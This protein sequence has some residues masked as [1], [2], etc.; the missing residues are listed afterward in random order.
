MNRSH[1][2]MGAPPTLRPRTRRSWLVL[3][4]A[5]PG[6]LGLAAIGTPAGAVQE[7]PAESYVVVMAAEPV[8]AYDGGE[9]GLAPTDPAVGEDID[10]DDPAVERYVE[11]LEAEQSEAAR[12]AGVDAADV[13]ERY[14]YAISGFEAELT[15]D[16]ASALERSTDVL[17]VVPN[18]LRQ[19]HTDVSPDFL[20]LDGPRGPYTW[21]YTGEDVVVGIIDSG[22][23][24]E[25]PSF[26]DDG[27]YSTLPGYEDLPCEFGNTAYNADD[28]PFDCNDKL[29]GARDFRDAYRQV[30]GSAETFDSARDYDGHGTHVASTAAGNAGVDAQIFGVDRGT[31]SGIAPRAR[32]IAYAA[33]GDLGCVTSDLVAAIDAAVADGVDV[34]NYSIGGGASITDATDLAFLFA[35]DAGVWVAT[36]AGNGGPG[37]QTVGSPASSPW[38][39]TVGASTHDRTFR[40]EGIL[41][42]GE[43]FTGVSIT[44]GTDGQLPLVDAADLGNELCDPEVTFTGD[45]S[46]KVVL[47]LRGVFARVEKSR[48]VAEQG[49]AGMI[50]YNPNDAQALVTDLHFVPSIHV[51]YTTGQQVAAYIDAAG[52]DATVALTAGEAAPTQGSVMADFSSRGPNVPAPDIIKPD[53]TAPG[54][55]ILAG[56]TPFPALG[57]PGQLF[58]SISGTSMSSPHVAGAYALLREAHPDWSAAM[59]KSA[60]MTTA[61]QD[62]VKEDGERPADPFDYGAGHIDL[63]GDRYISNPFTPGL[64]YDA[65][66]TDYLGFLCGADPSAFDDPESV[67]AALEGLGVAIN[68]VNLNQPSI[69]ASEVPGTLTVERTVRSVAD[70]EK[71]YQSVVEAP[72]GFDVEVSPRYLRIAPGE[73]ASFE[74]TFTRTDA[75][76]G[77][78]RFG[79]LEWQAR[80]NRVRSP[81]AVNAA[82]LDAP[83]E[84]EVSGT[85][86]TVEVP[87]QF[88]YDGEYD[89]AVHGPRA[90]LLRTGTVS[91]DPDQTFDPADPVGNA[92]FSTGV[93]GAAFIRVELGLEDLD[94]PDPNIDLDLFLYRNGDLIAASTSAGTNERI[95]LLLPEDGTY[96]L[97][98]HGWQTAGTDVD[99]TVRAV[100]V[101]LEPDTGAFTIVDEPEDAAIGV[102]GTVE[103]A[104]SN[105]REGRRYLGAVSHNGPNGLIGLTLIEVDATGEVTVIP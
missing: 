54:V 47:C 60:L 63:S 85:E 67:C 92:K 61:R 52:A 37:P 44:D 11:H 95:D 91:Q 3:A 68:P 49:G 21:G 71:V 100:R 29:L 93:G 98:V 45:I 57:A 103:V 51:N 59:A 32:V 23:W 97:Y 22:I 28:A 65:G 43:E 36:S 6:L 89:A 50:L 33:C 101:P 48:A 70:T 41:G 56:H 39:T 99:F 10:P 55:N 35:A 20:G 84:L 73:S 42:D 38:I 64:V 77:E 30:A 13:G 5:L 62:V 25:H 76:V 83:D 31:V 66:L 27:S 82:L 9:P 7:G 105:L 102:V 88:G 80:G 94:V 46:G 53:V 34:I 8:V 104:W 96:T 18:E 74:V 4:L 15:E 16:E 40:S 19:L 58:Q 75:P 78:W 2:D 90:E 24:P 14:T 17:K 1:H 72:P 79:A 26:A 81:I 87:V 69:G 12:D 86:G